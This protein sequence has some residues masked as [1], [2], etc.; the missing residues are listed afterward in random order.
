[1][2]S[3]IRPGFLMTHLANPILGRLGRFLRL[4]A[5]AVDGRHLPARD[6]AQP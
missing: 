1:M 5:A 6:V 3:Y 4:R 2:T